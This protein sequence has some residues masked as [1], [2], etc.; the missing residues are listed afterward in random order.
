[1]CECDNEC[2]C[3]E[4]KEIINMLWVVLVDGMTDKRTRKARKILFT[5]DAYACDDITFEKQGNKDPASWVATPRMGIPGVSIWAYSREIYIRYKCDEKTINM[6][7]KKKNSSSK[8]DQ[9][10]AKKYIV[11][12]ECYIERCDLINSLVHEAL[13]ARHNDPEGNAIEEEYEGSLV[14]EQ[15]A[16]ALGCSG[17]RLTKISK[18]KGIDVVKRRYRG[19]GLKNDKNYKPIESWKLPRSRKEYR[20]HWAKKI[21]K[22]SYTELKK[23]WKDKTGLTL[24]N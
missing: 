11:C 5:L 13:H 15:A 17:G 10:W 6:I 12:G 1:M 2:F 9:D 23:Y 16:R 21:F 18:K 4:V 3:D 24:P 20:K 7:E 19:S 14:G 22:K 8:K